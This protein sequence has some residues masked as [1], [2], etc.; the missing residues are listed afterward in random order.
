MKFEHSLISYTKINLKWLK[1][2]NI[3]HDTRKLLKENIGRTLFD[4]NCCNIFFLIHQSNRTK[5]K[6][7]KWDLIKF[8][9]F[10]IAKE[11]I[12]KTKRQPMNWE[13]TFANDITDNGLISKICKCARYK[14][15]IN[16]QSKNGQ[17]TWTLLQRIHTG[18]YRECEKMLCVTNF[19]ELQIKTTMSYYFIHVRIAITKK[20]TNKC[21][22]ECG[23]KGTL[24][25]C[26]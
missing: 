23:E 6:I 22:R 7:N 1:D 3:R 20:S 13:K 9:C 24:L 11:T 14:K 15:K 12:N 5:I 16:S 4:I 2:L 10:C 18:G 21:W 26:W 8:K 19:G 17:K 25:H